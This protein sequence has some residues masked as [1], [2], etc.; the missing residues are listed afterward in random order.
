MQLFSSDIKNNTKM[1]SKQSVNFID[2]NSVYCI[3][4]NV[5]RLNENSVNVKNYNN[6]YSIKY[7]K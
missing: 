6:V 1:L 2:N 7:L 4:C 5:N 3:F